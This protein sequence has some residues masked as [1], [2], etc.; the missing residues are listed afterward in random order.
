MPRDLEVVN[1][2]IPIRPNVVG[3]CHGQ[4]ISNGIVTIA[5]A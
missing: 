4:T 1:V 5:S 3:R 2:M